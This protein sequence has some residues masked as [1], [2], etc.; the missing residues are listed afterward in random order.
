MRVDLHMHTTA[1]D[2]A[3]SP[4]AVVKGAVEGRLDLIEQYC[5]KDVEMTRRL[6]ELGH[7]QGYLLYRDHEERKVRVPV[8]W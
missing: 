5:R 4:E 3:W 1:S 2:G 8:Q 6:F 7:D